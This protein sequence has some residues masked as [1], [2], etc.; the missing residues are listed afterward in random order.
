MKTRI[1]IDSTIDMAKRLLTALPLI[2]GAFM[3]GLLSQTSFPQ[4]V[5]RLLQSL[6]KSLKKLPKQGTVPLY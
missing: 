5:S 3:S 2:A 4:Q 1:I 6:K